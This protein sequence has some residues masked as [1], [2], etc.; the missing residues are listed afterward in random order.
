M[1]ILK[2]NIMHI[3]H[4]PENITQYEINAVYL[5]LKLYLVSLAT[6]VNFSL[7]VGLSFHIAVHIEKFNFLYI[8]NRSITIAYRIDTKFVILCETKFVY[9]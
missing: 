5:H 3:C 2:L 4:F 8:C 7:D 1:R 9:T 6:Y